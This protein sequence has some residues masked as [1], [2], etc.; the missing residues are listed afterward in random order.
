LI[1]TWDGHNENEDAG[2]GYH[3]NFQGF[4]DQTTP[5]VLLQGE[6][7]GVPMASVAA[8]HGF[9]LARSKDGALYS[10]GSNGNGQL[11]L[12]EPMCRAVEPRRVIALSQ[13]NIVAV[14]AGDS[15][16]LALT[17][18]G[19]LF[20]FGHGPDDK[21]NLADGY[22]ELLLY[23]AMLP[24]LIAG[25]SPSDRVVSISVSIGYSRDAFFAVTERGGLLSWGGGSDCLGH[26]AGRQMVKVPTLIEALAGVRVVSVSAGTAHVLALAGD[27]A[28]YAWGDSTGGKTGLVGRGGA[29]GVVEGGAVAGDEGHE[30]S[31][32]GGERTSIAMAGSESLEGAMVGGQDPPI[33]TIEYLPRRIREMRVHCPECQPQQYVTC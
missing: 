6:A 10:F 9:T 17:D 5:R 20:Y 12:G 16:G 29:E 15:R 27:G 23:Y 22:P 24:V 25:L 7:Q 31:Q 11:G 26:G 2:L 1:F 4:E 8:G 21:F 13:H 32:A 18:T 33:P 30:R 28:V 19:D 3:L 14:A